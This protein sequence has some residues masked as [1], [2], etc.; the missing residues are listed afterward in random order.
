MNESIN[1]R[2]MMAAF[3]K[4]LTLCAFTGMLKPKDAEILLKKNVYFSPT[5][6][7]VDMCLLG[8]KT[9]GQAKGEYFRIW[10]SSV[11]KLC[12]VQ[13]LYYYIK[14]CCDPEVGEIEY[15]STD[16]HSTTSSEATDLDDPDYYD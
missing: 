6:S 16:H 15:Y 7:Y 2:E 1:Y 14:C 11:K 12:P 10:N 3:M 8:F 4:S 5:L 13:A 9:D